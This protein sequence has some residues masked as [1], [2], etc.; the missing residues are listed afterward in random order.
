[1][2]E[3]VSLNDPRHKSDDS[4]A[5]FVENATKALN[6][7]NNAIAP[8]SDTK[9]ATS[10][11]SSRSVTPETGMQSQNATAKVPPKDFDGK[12]FEV[13]NDSITIERDVPSRDGKYLVLKIDDSNRERLMRFAEGAKV[14][15]RFSGPSDI[16]V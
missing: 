13:T 8:S 5:T 11:Q 14:T 1:M 7:T 9:G 4:K 6:R 3:K 12:V 10:A 15:V 16:N 2:E